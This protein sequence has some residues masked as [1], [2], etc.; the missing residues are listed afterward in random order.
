MSGRKNQL[1]L[2]QLESHLQQLDDFEKPKIDLEQ[3]ATPSHVAA[4]I[5]NAIDSDDLNGRLVADLGCGTGRL[6]V[7]SLICGAQL[8]VGFDI[9]QDALD[10]ALKNISNEFEEEEKDD[11]VPN[12]VYTDCP[13][14]NFVIADVASE[15]FNEFWTSFDKKFDTVIMNPPF[16]TKK[17]QGLDMAFLKRAIQ[18]SNNVVYSLHKTSTR[19]VS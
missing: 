13:S 18:I 15:E 9:D 12:S 3:Y 19:D 5:L 14:V 16:G 2:R 10:C 8:V 6:T 11:E 4:L 17:V 7:G 1:S